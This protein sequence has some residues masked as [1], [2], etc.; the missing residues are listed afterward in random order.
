MV[1]RILREGRNLKKPIITGISGILIALVLTLTNFAGVFSVKAY[2]A[3]TVVNDSSALV[4]AISNASEDPL[5]PTVIELGADIRYTTAG[6]VVAAGKY[7]KL[8]LGGKTLE[9]KSITVA[10][11]LT[12]EGSGSLIGVEDYAIL[13]GAGGEFTLSGGNLSSTYLSY[14]ISALDSGRFVMTGGNITGANDSLIMVHSGATFEMRG[15]TVTNTSQRG[16]AVRVYGVTV[17]V[18]GG[19]IENTNGGY[20]LKIYDGGQTTQTGG[21]VSGSIDTIGS[22]SFNYVSGT[23]S[24]YQSSSGSSSSSVSSSADEDYTGGLMDKL[25]EAAALGGKQTIDWNEGEALSYGIMKFLEDHPDITLV[26]SYTYLDKD[27]KVTIPGSKVKAD[28]MIPWYGPLYLFGKYGRYE[29]FPTSGTYTV[30]SGDTL[31]G[32]AA[33]LNISVRH[34]VQENSIEDP[35]FIRAGQM[36]KY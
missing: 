35:D 27:Y 5:N 8:D 14:V 22:G 13:I 31:S 29:A 17:T 36:L 2:A 21:T 12:V 11:N 34:L 6:I 4:T 32:I 23:N 28:V 3:A 7:V 30:I 9:V 18:S 1:H 15:G 26:F 33:K 19:T 20:A 25:E 16:A 24:N 10:G